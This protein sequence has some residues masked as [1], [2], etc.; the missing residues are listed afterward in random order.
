MLCYDWSELNANK[1]RRCEINQKNNNWGEESYLGVHVKS[2]L[3]YNVGVKTDICYL[4]TEE[5]RWE[6]GVFMNA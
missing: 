6:H 2:L 4:F 3:D 5:P 1:E